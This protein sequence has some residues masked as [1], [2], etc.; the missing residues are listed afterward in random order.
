MSKNS[1]DE[2]LKETDGRIIYIEQLLKLLQKIG[3]SLEESNVI[4]KAYAKKQID[5]VNIIE[6]QFKNLLGDDV[7]DYLISKIRSDCGLMHW[8]I[9]N[10]TEKCVMELENRKEI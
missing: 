2:L 4:R 7:A 6:T 9:H 3:Y 1:V 5:K 10:N 8:R